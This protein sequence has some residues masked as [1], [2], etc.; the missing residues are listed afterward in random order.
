MGRVREIR[1]HARTS[2]R[3]ELS[4]ETLGRAAPLLSTA[5]KRRAA[6]FS[7]F[8]TLLTAN[9]IVRGRRSPIV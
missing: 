3:T 9:A 7:Q 8:R 1:L 6:E 2:E 5:R 4:A